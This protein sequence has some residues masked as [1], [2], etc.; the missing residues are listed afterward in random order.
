MMGFGVVRTAP[1]YWHFAG[2]YPTQ[3]EA[4]ARAA[5]LGQ[6]YEVHYGQHHVG[7]EYF[8]WK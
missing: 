4:E 7:T 8:S 6:E 2:L 5:K 3:D 1:N